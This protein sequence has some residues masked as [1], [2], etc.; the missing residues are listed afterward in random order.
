MNKPFIFFQ[1]MRNVS[2]TC[3]ELSFEIKSLSMK[4]LPG[5]ILQKANCS[6]SYFH[7]GWSLRNEGVSQTSLD[8]RRTTI[9]IYLM[10]EDTIRANTRHT[11]YALQ[12]CSGLCCCFLFVLFVFVKY[13][14][15]NK[16]RRGRAR[17]STAKELQW[18][19]WRSQ[20]ITATTMGLEGC[21]AAIHTLL[22]PWLSA[23]GSCIPKKV[24]LTTQGNSQIH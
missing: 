22:L 16:G 17:A 18:K 12:K 4:Q 5:L 1:T 14:E 21:A 23:V 19:S 6:H 8:H 2:L 10:I 24:R 13:S 3:Q 7:Q 20:L 11:L 9:N 15:P